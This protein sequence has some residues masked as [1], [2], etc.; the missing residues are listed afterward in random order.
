MSDTRI[1]VRFSDEE[2][3]KIA[4]QAQALGMTRADVLRLAVES[5]FA[6]NKTTSHMAD[7]LGQHLEEVRRE[8]ASATERLSLEHRRSILLLLKVLQAPKDAEAALE[9]IYGG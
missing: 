7:M 2:N 4:A 6:A 5:L 3:R 9:K 8:I 1:T